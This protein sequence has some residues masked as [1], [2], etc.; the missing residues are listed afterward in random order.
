LHSTCS[1]LDKT[2]EAETILSSL[3]DERWTTSEDSDDDRNGWWWWTTYRRP[4]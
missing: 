3:Q 1:K 4:V 2:E